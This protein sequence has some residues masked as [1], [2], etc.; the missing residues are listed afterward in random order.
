[1]QGDAKILEFKDVNVGMTPKNEPAKKKP[2]N[3]V[4]HQQ[5]F[6]FNGNHFFEMARTGQV[7]NIEVTAKFDKKEKIVQHPVTFKSNQGYVMLPQFKAYSTFAM[8]FQFKTIQS[9]GL[10]FYNAGKGNDFL[11]VELVNGN[12]N[13]VFN[14]GSGPRTVTTNIADPLNYNKW[15]DIVI[16]RPTLQQHILRVDYSY[17]KTDNLPD[18]TSVHYDLEGDLYIGGVMKSMYNALPKQIKSRHGY[19]GCM[20]SLDL[21]SERPEIM[22]DAT[23]PEDDLVVEGCDGMYHNSSLTDS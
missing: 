1:M 23:I 15:H 8:N 16:L 11:A 13:Y 6:I 14:V 4:G 22:K 10:L 12:I 19:Q 5:Q 7:K 21:N 3:F 20:A 9:N 18:S 17:T 2:S